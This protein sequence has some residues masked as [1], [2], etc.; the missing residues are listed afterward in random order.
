VGQCRG[1]TKKGDR[2]R[3]EAVSGSDHCSIHKEMDAQ[4][5][6]EAWDEDFSDTAKTVLGIAI[7]A[8]II[9]AYLIRGR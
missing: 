4:E 3:R 2:C 6:G 7:A 8:I 5:G 1:T 9:F